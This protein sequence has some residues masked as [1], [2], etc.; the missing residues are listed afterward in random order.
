MNAAR[1]SETGLAAVNTGQTITFNTPSEEHRVE[2][3]DLPPFIDWRGNTIQ[4]DDTVLYPP[5]GFAELHECV[6]I[7]I[8]Q[9]WRT[10][11]AAPWV[12]A[13]ADTPIPHGAEVAWRALLQ[14]VRRSRPFRL[15]P[16]KRFSVK[17]TCNLTFLAR[18]GQTQHEQIEDRGTA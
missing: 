8:C 16:G 11:P 18:G 4:V 5:P 12:R 2:P 9:K 15:D 13:T 10:T 6:V 7:D 3:A 17:E 14:A 1:R